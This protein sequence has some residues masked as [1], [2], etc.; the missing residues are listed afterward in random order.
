[1]ANEPVE[2]PELPPRPIA[3]VRI[4]DDIEQTQGRGCLP[5]AT[6]FLG[7]P[8][9]AGTAGWLGGLTA[10][11][12]AAG[13][14]IL[15]VIVLNVRNSSFRKR[16]RQR[17]MQRKERLTPQELAEE[18][19]EVEEYDSLSKQR[20]DALAKQRAAEEDRNKQ[21]AAEVEAAYQAEDAGYAA[22]VG[23]DG[24]GLVR[25]FVELQGL[26]WGH[27]T[28]LSQEERSIDRAGQALGTEEAILHV[29]IGQ[30]SGL[31]FQALVITTRRVCIVGRDSTDWIPRSRISRCSTMPT[32]RGRL[33]VIESQRG[34][35]RWWELQP[36][37]AGD[38][39]VRTL[40]RVPGQPEPIVEARGPSAFG[41]V[42]VATTAKYLGGDFTGPDAR[43]GS[44]FAQRLAEGASVKVELTDDHFVVIR[45]GR[46]SLA[47]YKITDSRVTVDEATSIGRGVRKGRLAATAAA[48]LVLGPVALVG[49]AASTAKRV[50][51]SFAMAIDDGQDYGLFA[52]TDSAVGSRIAAAQR[53][54]ATR[55]DL[56][57][58]LP[59]DEAIEQIQRLVELQESGAITSAEFS[60]LKNSI[61]RE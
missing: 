37:A 22:V 47:R 39:I 55:T 38:A 8:I 9:V 33:L 52:L 7:T 27:R 61:L 44:G 3:H 40:R 59:P 19:R 46:K 1:M 6:F 31:G 14:V 20:R 54:K 15:A 32:A 56:A 41:A 23:G 60:Q 57:Q 51:T 50:Q 12:I 48:S 25:A 43:A 34:T 30:T 28:W 4:H 13:F 26:P 2:V 53:G 58:S 36:K 24:R 11:A 49:L 42:V 5:F 29:A 16:L 18:K 21:V 17:E 10:A 35:H 45:D